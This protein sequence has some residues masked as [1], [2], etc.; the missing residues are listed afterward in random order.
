MMLV[1]AGDTDVTTYFTIRTAAD[2]TATTGATITDIDL[3]YVRSGSA[4]AAKADATALASTSATHTDNAAIE[5]DGTN[6][7]GLYRVDWPDAA[8]AA[9]VSEV[10]LSV[11][12]ASSFTEHL[13]VQ[14]DAPVDGPTKAE[15][16]SAFSTTD[17]KIDTVDTEVG[18]IK[19]VVD[20]ILEDTGTT[21]PATLSTIDSEIG[22]IDTV[23]DAIKV[24]TDQ[25]AFTASNQLDVQVLSMATDSI[26]ASAAAA[27]F[28]GASEIAASASTEIADKIAADWVAGDAS[29]LAIVAALKADSEWSNLATID[30]NID[31]ILED[32]GTT[33]PATITTIDNEI[34]AIKTVVDDVETDTTSIETKVDLIDTFVD[35]E[36]AAIK[37]VVDA[38]LE[39]TGTT[40][41]ATI[42]TIDN[43]IAAIKTVVDNVETDTTAIEADTQSIE[44]KIDA[45]PSDADVKTQCDSAL[46]DIHLD[47]LLAVDYDPGDKPGAATALL[48]EM[49]ESHGGVS[50]FTE[51]ALAEAPSGGG[52]GG[53]ATEAKQD[54]IIAAVITNAA[55]TD[56]AADIIAIKA[57][58]AAIKTVV[59]DIET[60]TQ[61][62]EAKVDT[63][64]TEIGAI[65]TV[66]DN[67]ET[68]TTAIEA[69]TQSIETKI[70]ALPSAADVKTQCDSALSDL[71]LD[72]LFTVALS[73]QPE[74]GS[75]LA[76]LTEDDGGTQRF[77]QEAL[78]EAPSGSGAAASTIAEAVWDLS[79]TGR[80][81][82]GTFGAQAKTVVDRIEVDT[83]DIQSTLSTNLPNVV[84][85][86]NIGA[87][88]DSS[89]SDIHLD[90]LFAADYDVANPPG[91]GTALLNELVQDTGSTGVAQFTAGA[92]A[93]APTG[94]GGTTSLNG[95]VL[96]DT[97]INTPNSQTELVLTAGSPSDDAYNNLTIVIEND[98][99]ASDVSVH[100]ITNYDGT[101]KAVTIANTPAF[102]VGPA[103]KVYILGMKYSDELTA[104]GAAA[105]VWGAD[106]SSYVA[107]ATFGAFVN[108]LDDIESDTSTLIDTRIPDTISLANI[109]TQA[110][111]ALTDF[112]VSV[113]TLIDSI[114]TED[115]S[116]HTGAGTSGNLLV[117]TSTDM[118]TL[119]DTRIPDTISLANIKTQADSALTDIHLD[120]LLANEYDAGSKPGD[121][122]ALLN[123]MVEDAG[124]G[125]SRFTAE[126]LGQGPSAS[127]AN[128]TSI[129]GTSLSESTGGRI[130]A[131]W[132]TFFENADA[133]TSSVLDDVGGGAS[134]NSVQIISTTVA[135][136]ESTV[137]YDLVA[138]SPDDDCYNHQMVM[139]IDQ[140]DNAQRSVRR[141]SDYSQADKRISIDSAPDFV[142]APG[143]VVK[144][145]AVNN[146]VSLVDECTSNTDMLT[147]SAVNDEVD[148]S[149]ITYGLDHL[150]SEP[151]NDVDI[152][153]NSIIA[154]LV[155]AS[156]TATW[157][158]FDNTTNSLMALPSQSGVTTLVQ[159]VIEDNELDHLL[160]T[161]YNPGSKPGSGTS[162]LNSLIADSGGVSQFTERA[163][164]LG[165]SGD[166]ALA[167][168]VL[169]NTTVSS[170]NAGQTE[171]VLATG[172]VDDDC[173]NGR[174]I[175]FTDSVVP[176]Q[177]S[178]R[179]VLDYDQ[180][181]KTVT[182]D[183]SPD[184]VVA[185]DD[186]C[187]IL[188][189][190][191]LAGSD[192]ADELET[193]DG[194]RKSE[195]DSAIAAVGA[196]PLVLADTT[197]SG[198]ANQKIFNMSWPGDPGA[199]EPSSDGGAYVGMLAII[200]HQD[201]SERRQV[202]I[203]ASY[204]GDPNHTVTL[205]NSPGVFLTTNGDRIQII[206]VPTPEAGAGG[207]TP[208]ET[209]Q[210]RY[211]V[212]I[213]GTQTE[214]SSNAPALATLANQT[215]THNRMGSWSGTGVNT[216]LG[217]LQAV[218][219]K[220]ASLPSDIGGSMDPASASVEALRERGDIAWLSATASSST[221]S[222][223]DVEGIR[224]VLNLDGTQT[225]PAVSPAPRLVVN[226][227]E[228]EG[229]DAT[230]RINQACD[231]ALTD[232]GAAKP[233]DVTTAQTSIEDDIAA[234]SVPTAAAVTSAVWGA[235]SRTLTDKTGFSLTSAERDAISAL[236]QVDLENLTE[237]EVL[238]QVSSGLATYD[239]PT[240]GEA[241]ADKDAISALIQGLAN[242]GESDVLAQ[243]TAAL[244]SYDP[245]TRQELSDDKTEII[246]EISGL[247][248]INLSG[249]AS[250]VVTGLTTYDAVTQADLDSAEAEI[251]SAVPSAGG[252]VALAVTNT[253]QTG[254]ETI[255]LKRG[256]PDIL[257]FTGLSTIS[258]SDVLLGIGDS[259][260]RSLLK[261]EGT[262]LTTTSARFEISPTQA[263]A[264]HEGSF[265]L[266]VFE[267]ESYNAATGSY[268]D[269]RWLVGGNVTIEPLA[270]RL[271]NT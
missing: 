31:L 75:L 2:G 44:A 13:R 184:F 90:H 29:P 49:V 116:S 103:D 126:A 201:D 233:L 93:Q 14:L 254:G 246:N 61:S 42:T 165:P 94:S 174:T 21:L 231:E 10:V 54:E 23:A 253:G 110:D 192:I 270:L 211:W 46:S 91:T 35:T 65:K 24:V 71:R 139:F 191:G 40:I 112:F 12:L 34:A 197:V 221:L 147:A 67:V 213:D 202:G 122:N 218:L 200:T 206:A 175:V 217:G 228:I 63:V 264:L 149:I 203:V 137:L 154:K 9:G 148:N 114:W 143:D 89:L 207:L 50:R 4:P 216:I 68:D 212:G 135:T 242:L 249:I 240:R 72:E 52:G 153:N 271:E 74:T 198:I 59:D 41:P 98:S 25:M 196:G 53:D 69:D 39:D 237:A 205:R 224:Y 244:T 161:P 199:L 127:N 60:D 167:P 209:D 82:A 108:L 257:T 45:L 20:S 132:K 16:D 6:Q 120:H 66:V 210:L 96:H 64:D 113:P 266:D 214:P 70:D 77:T 190:P 159:G 134:T 185:A 47:H 268:T 223:D 131:N 95:L 32:T 102:T 146:H 262:I 157:S 123:E 133:V 163:L 130:A 51:E 259:S 38:I 83:Q 125:D 171:V 187:V 138:G 179:R 177:K 208:S 48:N 204:S 3:T 62:I 152:E 226:T 188:S 227:T 104:S 250:Q 73:V 136:V 263:L 5:V 141:I 100:R 269:T 11:K 118:S 247:E 140:S 229:Q 99:D 33:L 124:S 243:V 15:M 55:G 88:V 80:T 180:A 172:S 220:S 255:I 27:D 251:L 258:M 37:T 186:L 189:L 105:A 43:E 8:F 128:L 30:A 78:A 236:L 160:L 230:D 194:P 56:V 18:A 145:F 248:N 235:A 81:T 183:S 79:T 234:L 219:S 87:Q 151:V 84:S 168:L 156:A 245:P 117:G 111:S 1:K 182:L 193:Y 162:L 173:Y 119:V 215:T 158:N 76:D 260:G 86:A 267:C 106:A 256:N 176:S 222:S 115:M 109:K 7:P 57:E 155:S 150:V 241:T 28:I 232:Y 97:T 178:V 166:G 101:T 17:G 107:S 144:I 58:T 252:T 36:V 261:L 129:L 164:Q 85:L 26:T 195:M 265:Q 181:T 92:L 170:I 225:A 169:V 121:A 239:P 22:D 142:I 238:A 19:T